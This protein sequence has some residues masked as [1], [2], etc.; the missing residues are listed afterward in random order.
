MTN[1][2]KMISVCFGIIISLSGCYSSEVVTREIDV[3]ITPSQAT[4]EQEDYIQKKEELQEEVIEEASEK[5][6]RSV[7]SFNE[8]NRV[9]YGEWEIVAAPDF[10]EERVGKRYSINEEQIIYDGEVIVK[11]PMYRIHTYFVW[12]TIRD[13]FDEL[14][15]INKKYKWWDEETHHQ[16]YYIRVSNTDME[17]DLV[18]EV[19]KSSR[20]MDPGCVLVIDRDTIISGSGAY[21]LKRIGEMPIYQR[22]VDEIESI[23]IDKE[24]NDSKEA[25]LSGS[26]GYYNGS[27]QIYYGDW[28]VSNIIYQP[29]NL[30]IKEQQYIQGLIGNT[31]SMSSKHVI[32][33]KEYTMKDVYYSMDILPIENAGEQRYIKEIPML[34]DLGLTGKYFTFVQIQEFYLNEFYDKPLRN[35]FIKDHNTLIA[36]EKGCCLELVRTTPLTEEELNFV[37]N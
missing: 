29:E 12:Q 2:I 37:I 15:E 26:N 28:Q 10:A 30:N 7:Y 1:M 3:E 17:Y 21:V 31:V 8:A 36:V 11:K 24:N 22:T 19:A 27:C 25:M 13:Y 35:F 34:K 33:N 18:D 23:K 16:N 14:P 4:D 20:F 6:S 9:F 5:I 32:F